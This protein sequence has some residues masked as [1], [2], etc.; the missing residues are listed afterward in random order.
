M[1]K[2]NTSRFGNFTFEVGVKKEEVTHA[3]K[4][5]LAFKK[6]AMLFVQQ[7]AS[8]LHVDKVE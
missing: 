5:I 2:M 6:V 8:D 3:L 7:E 1:K 4:L